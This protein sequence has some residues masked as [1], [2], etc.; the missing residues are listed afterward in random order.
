MTEKLLT[1]LQS[2]DD[3]IKLRTALI[4]AIKTLHKIAA[5]PKAHIEEIDRANVARLRLK[6]IMKLFEAKGPELLEEVEE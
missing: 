5:Y 6:H 3:P 4:L 1:Q 2:I